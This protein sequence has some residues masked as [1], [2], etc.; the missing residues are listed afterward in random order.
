METI[1]TTQTNHLKVILHIESKEELSPEEQEKIY[2][3]IFQDKNILWHDD[4]TPYEYMIDIKTPEDKKISDIKCYSTWGD[5]AGY[6]RRIKME[7]Y[8]NYA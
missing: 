5:V 7:F 1:F 6:E 8:V 3:Y 4:Y 2:E